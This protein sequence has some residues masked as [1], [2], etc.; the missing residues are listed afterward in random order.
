MSQNETS[1]NQAN[2]L[3]RQAEEKAAKMTENLEGL[4]QVEIRQILHELR[5][6][7]IELEMQ[8][9]ELRGFQTELDS[10][11]ERYFDLFDLA[12]VGYCT[13]SKEGLILEANLTASSLLG[14]V[15]GAL[16]NQ[17]ITRF[18]FKGDQDT[19]FLLRKNL[20]EAYSVSSGQA[21]APRTCEL[22]MVKNNGALFWA[23]LKITAV[24]DTDSSP[25]CRVVMSDI[26]ERKQAEMMLQRNESRLKK[27]LDI[28][29][30]PSETIQD[31]L[32]YAL[33]QAIQLTESKIGYIYHFD[34]CSKKFVLNTW[35]KEVMA[36]C[37]IANPSTCYELEKTGIWGEVVRQRRPIII[38]DFQAVNPLKKGYPEGHVQLLKFMTVPIFKNDNIVSVIGLANKE[39]DY[40]EPDIFQVSLL[41]KTVWK[42]TERKRAEDALRESEER[43]RK[44]FKNHAAIKLV[45]DP[46]T[47]SIIDANEASAKFYGWPVEELKQMRIQ[48][49]NMLP[50]E[51]VKAKMEKAASSES[52]RFEFRHRRA[53]SSIRDVEVFSNKIEVAGKGLLYSI[54]HD[55]T[56]RKQV[57]EQLLKSES[58]FRK[59]FEVASVGIVQADAITGRILQCNE[60][61]CK[62]TGY[63]Q[64]ELLEV[65]FPEITHPDD[66]QPDWKIFFEAMSGE[67]PTYYNEKRYIRKDGSIIWVRLNAAF[68]RDSNGQATRTVAICEDIT[69]RKQAQESLRESEKMLRAMLSEKE[70][71]IKEIH[72]RVKN[73]LQIISS[74]ISLQSDFLTDKRL[75]WVLSDMCNRVRTI[76]LVH[77]RIY[78]TD[79]LARLNIAEYAD[80]LM[81]SLWFAFGAAADK[82]RLNLSREP[83]LF[84]V[85]TAVLCG[86]ILNELASNTIK[87]AFPDGRGGE[88]TVTLEHDP[89]TG[90]V[91]LRV[92]DNGVGLPADLDWRQFNSLGLRLVQMLAKQMR[93]TVETGPGPGT[94]FQINFNV[95]GIPS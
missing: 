42:V 80:S 5:V 39:T 84:P 92:R 16:V 74:M 81:Q 11:R 8:N 37:A 49:I 69:E 62:I 78:Q 79:D 33:D 91:S 53:D 65:N 46:E 20:F 85:G 3:R 58:Q 55:I 24:Q 68:V 40:E 60:T 72:H 89:A 1:S 18:I 34:E 88:V 93:G 54:V 73:N 36:E 87:H 70:V 21:G 59:I 77:E 82:V 47:G 25:V 44:L 22:R 56:E 52:A 31:F 66:R 23:Q 64:P 48:Q 27:L 32:D 10:A 90:A 50:P 19:F 75:Q 43:F 14:M 41:M 17:P 4:S 7:Q 13:I 9:E 76:A 38:N 2:N 86:L 30:H 35:S 12:P 61:Y 67:K 71:L 26:T 83:V 15:R 57:E 95:K 29:Q 6:H 45:I 63:S 28:L 51:T 94:E